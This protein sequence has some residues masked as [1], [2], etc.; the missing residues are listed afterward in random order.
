MLLGSLLGT[1]GFDQASRDV[2]LL[3]LA[4]REQTEENAE[5]AKTVASQTHPQESRFPAAPRGAGHLAQKVGCRLGP[6]ATTGPTRSQLVQVGP[7]LPLLCAIDFVK[8]T[9]SNDHLATK[10]HVGFP[11]RTM[12]F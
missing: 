6:W 4:T 7:G 5:A 11:R 2:G 3:G 1:F 10:L 9:L 8:I 12:E